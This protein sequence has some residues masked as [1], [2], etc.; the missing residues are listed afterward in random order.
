[1]MCLTMMIRRVRIGSSRQHRTTPT[2]STV[3]DDRTYSSSSSLSSSFAWGA[4]AAA[5]VALSSNDDTPRYYGTTTAFCEAPKQPNKSSSSVDKS[6]DSFFDMAQ[7]WARRVPTTVK[8]KLPN[9]NDNANNIDVAIE[10]KST[11]GDILKNN[12]NKNDSATSN[13]LA[14]LL[15]AMGILGGVTK[16]DG[17]NIPPAVV[18]EHVDSKGMMHRMKH[19]IESSLH[20]VGNV[21]SQQSDSKTLVV[22]ESNS[23]FTDPISFAN[24]ASMFTKK[25]GDDIEGLIQQAQQIVANQGISS[26]SSFDDGASLLSPLPTTSSYLSQIMYFQQNAKAIQRLFKSFNDAQELDLES[27]FPTNPVSSLHYYLEAEDAKKT[28]SWKRRIHRFHRS[29]DVRKVN[30]LNEALLLCELSYADSVEDIRS[31]LATLYHHGCKGVDGKENELNNKPQWELLFCDTESRPNEPSH[32]LAIQKNAL[33]YDDILH[34]LMVVRGTKSMSDLITDAMME[35]SDYD[36]AIPGVAAKVGE[37]AILR[38]KAHSGM[39]L[40]GKYLVNRHHTLLST[41][42]ELSKKC[43]IEI[44]LIGHSL[45][46]GAATIAAMEW[47]TKPFGRA[48]QDQTLTDAASV[49]NTKNDIQ[50]SAHVIGFGCP[51]LL[52][53]NLSL[54][55]KEHV[56]TVIADADFIPRMSGATLVNLLLNVKRFDY[57]K[58]VE[59]DIEQ[60]LREVQSRVSSSDDSSKIMPSI[61][62]GEDNIQSVMGYI[63]RGMET[64]ATTTDA[65]DVQVEGKQ[66]KKKQPVLFPPGDCIHFYRDGSGISGAFVPCD[67]FNEVRVLTF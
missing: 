9:S 8:D 33:P 63:R 22:D 4:A 20:N 12:S 34:V 31:G 52:S 28:P 48:K 66:I 16:T 43:K 56:T 13:P 47:N 44:T 10:R 46:A 39:Q 60:A 53:N 6:N 32:F 42:L 37:N 18:D 14:S 29:V 23:I 3:D 49:N 59:R 7:Q 15:D 38:G 26:S 57:C 51:A 58:E 40:S 25:S 1:M 55:T 62:I 35:A 41:L 2:L 45:G 50:V 54:A 27:L 19:A 17:I 24:S 5:V 30:E 65:I 11:G 67:F 61:N 21:H 64:V 36:Y